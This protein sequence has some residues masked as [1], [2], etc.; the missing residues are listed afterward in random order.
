[1]TETN[2]K[3]STPFWREGE[4]VR[5][6]SAISPRKSFYSRDVKKEGGKGVSWRV[7]KVKKRVC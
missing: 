1:M 3:K 2:A 6:G 7:V 4:K 5:R